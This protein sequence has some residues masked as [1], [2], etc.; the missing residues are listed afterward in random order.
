MTSRVMPYDTWAGRLYV[1]VVPAHIDDVGQ[2][3]EITPRL[4]VTTGLVKDER[5]Y[6]ITRSVVIVRDQRFMV[7]KMFLAVGSG[8]DRRFV[9]EFGVTTAGIYGLSGRP[10][11]PRTV[12]YQRILELVV[13]TAQQFDNE[14]PDWR[15]ESAILAWRDRIVEAETKTFDYLKA[16]DDL[17]DQI[18]QYRIEIKTLTP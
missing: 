10:V 17:Q 7:D 8:E 1:I 15:D 11:G 4:R 12:T 13:Y 9:S 16:I 5:L 6:D 18:A 3:R 2:P 14:Q